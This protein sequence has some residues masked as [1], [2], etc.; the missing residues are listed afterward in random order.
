MKLTSHPR[1]IAETA[2]GA[3][4]GAVIAGPVGAVAGGLAG[5]QAGTAPPSPG[6][7]PGRAAAVPDDFLAHV[8]V[9]RMLVPVDFSRP[10][11]QAVRF[12][13]EWAG[14]F[15]SEVHLVHVVEPVYPVTVFG[16]GVITPPVPGAEFHS[17]AGAALEK[18]AKGEFPGSTKVSVQLREGP[19][20]VEIA[21]AARE[22]KADLIV[23]ASHG[24][25]GLARVL[26]GSTSERVTRH[27]PCP[28]LTLRRAA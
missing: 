8:A 9:K 18:L 5:S 16:N 22:L 3:A 20:F 25:T 7:E 26:M 10:S 12:A 28:V 2:V 14:R 11:L 1:K 4:V 27:A 24:Q 21:A 19:A 15:G 17:H 13:R 23:M 6:A